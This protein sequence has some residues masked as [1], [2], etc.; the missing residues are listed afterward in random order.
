MSAKASP[1]PVWITRS[2]QSAPQSAKAVEAAGFTPLIAP[3]LTIAAA[4]VPAAAPADDAVLAFTSPNGVAAFAALSDKRHYMIY[5][6]GDATADKAKALGFS[7]MASA[8]G[9]VDALAKLI[10]ADKPSSVVHY[11]GVHVAGDLVGALRAAGLEASRQIIYAA[12]A[13][14]DLPVAARQA[15]A[16]HKRHAVL[17]YSPKGARTFLS[18]MQRGGFA[19]RYADMIMVS[20][21]PNIDAALGQGTFF[22]RHI[23]DAPNEAALISALERSLQSA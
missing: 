13:V 23:A 11:S 14:A 4:G 19:G 10:I 9:D 2:D 16:E 20:L 8:H 22:A 18:V 5:A 17:L 21:S 6:V 7:Y 3:L 12:Q 1:C 15:L